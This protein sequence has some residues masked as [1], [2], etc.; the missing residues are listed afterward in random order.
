MYP[1][2]SS[3]QLF[4]TAIDEGPDDP[5]YIVRRFDV[6]PDGQLT[7]VSEFTY[8]SD[9]DSLYASPVITSLDGIN[10]YVV[11]PILSV[12]TAR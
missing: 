8:E 9:D 11:F 12:S 1:H 6:N 5:V 2:P 7:L 10:V 3:L 4:S